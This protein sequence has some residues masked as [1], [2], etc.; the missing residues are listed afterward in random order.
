M[1]T[2][3]QGSESS[4]DSDFSVEYN[5][6]VTIQSVM[7]TGSGS[8]ESAETGSRESAESSDSDECNETV[9]DQPVM[10]Y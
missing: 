1:D 3:R 4:D 10:E 2:G 8:S 6:T 9:T 5:K 7:E